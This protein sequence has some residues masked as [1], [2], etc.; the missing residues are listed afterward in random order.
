M[1]DDDDDNRVNEHNNK[2]PRG[3]QLMLDEQARLLAQGF[4]AEAII[5]A[6]ERK[7]AKLTQL[8]TRY[9]SDTQ[10]LWDKGLNDLMRAAALN[11]CHIS[12]KLRATRWHA[13]TAADQQTLAEHWATRL[14]PYTP[15]A[16]T[17]AAAPTL[18]EQ[19]RT[20][21]ARRKNG[22]TR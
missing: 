17:P 21:R 22:A 12:H 13:L 16:T 6:A 7:H 9:G 2:I 11:A 1:T 19:L 14:R 5:D 18:A 4:T 8:A 3:Y 20:A 15:I 10:S